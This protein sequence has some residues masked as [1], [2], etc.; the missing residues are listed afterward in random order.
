MNI[1]GGFTIAILRVP[2]IFS[3]SISALSNFGYEYKLSKLPLPGTT[4]MKLFVSQMV[5]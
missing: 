2:D 3:D 1:S 5:K 4:L